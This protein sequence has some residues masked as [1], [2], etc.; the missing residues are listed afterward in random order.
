MKKQL[1]KMVRDLN[2]ESKV[3]LM[4]QRDNIVDYY[5]QSKIFI[6][7]SIYEGFPNVLVEALANQCPII[8]TNCPSWAK[9]N[10]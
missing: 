10:N 4:G 7:S 8:S 1:Q 9:R 5:I 3:Y 2:L 6:L